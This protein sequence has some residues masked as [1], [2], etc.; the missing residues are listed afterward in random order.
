MKNNQPVTGVE[1]ELGIGVN[2]LSTTDLKGTITYI[3]Q[4][5]IDISGFSDTELLHKNHNVVRHPDEQ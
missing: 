4:D 3:N 5:F 2:I 1:R